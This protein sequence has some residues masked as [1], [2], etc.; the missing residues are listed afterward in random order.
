MSDDIELICHVLSSQ[1]QLSNEL[2]SPFVLTTCG[3]LICSRKLL[4]LKSYS[5]VIFGKLIA[6]YSA[7]YNTNSPIAFDPSERNIFETFKS[8]S[9]YM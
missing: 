1:F 3:K 7:K 4:L 9:M 6:T 5:S 8:V 2:S